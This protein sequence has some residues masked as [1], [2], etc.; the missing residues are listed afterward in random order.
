MEKDNVET[1]EIVVST[2]E[3]EDFTYDLEVPAGSPRFMI[4]LALRGILFENDWT[5]DGTQSRIRR[6][7]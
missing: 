4:D 1:W 7:S 3:G 2:D 5:Q 6:V